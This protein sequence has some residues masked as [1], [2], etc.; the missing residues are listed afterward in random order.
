MKPIDSA[1]G[2]LSPCAQP[3]ASSRSGGFT[4]LFEMTRG[5]V[6]SVMAM[7]LD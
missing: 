2:L 4:E 6:E 7:V 5:G 3:A 1:G